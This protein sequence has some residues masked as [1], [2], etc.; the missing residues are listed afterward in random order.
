[1]EDYIFELLHSIG[2]TQADQLDMNH[3]AKLL[4]VKISYKRKFYSIG[5]EIILSNGDVRDEWFS[6]AHELKHVLIDKGNQLIMPKSFRE[7]QEWKADLF[8]YHFCVPTF[9]LDDLPQLNTNDIT[10]LFNVTHDVATRRLE[11][12][13]SKLYT[14]SLMPV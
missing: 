12:Y 3:I 4:G 7:F 8:A 6:F 1:M 5:N 2:I 10:R 14:R 13:E 9:M 11:M